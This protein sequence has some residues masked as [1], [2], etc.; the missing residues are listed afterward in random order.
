MSVQNRLKGI[1]VSL[2]FTSAAGGEDSLAKFKN[3][4]IVFDGEVISE[5]YVGEA[6][7]L[8]DMIS[9]GVKV[10]ASVH[11][12][13]PSVFDFIGRVEDVRQRRATGKFSV[14]GRFAFPDGQIRRVVVPDLQLGA[15]P[16]RTTGRKEYVGL[17]IDGAA[18]TAR[19]IK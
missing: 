15:L 8:F 14:V 10:K 5:D 1:D 16:I 17:D 18:E 3:F 11:P 9:N 7:P 13:D 4:E 12:N 6:T 2:V 19:V